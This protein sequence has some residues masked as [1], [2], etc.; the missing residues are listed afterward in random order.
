MITKKKHMN[1]HYTQRMETNED[2]S[3]YICVEGLEISGLVYANTFKYQVTYDGIGGKER[4]RV[5]RE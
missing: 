3:H 5:G 4:R 2:I 1:I